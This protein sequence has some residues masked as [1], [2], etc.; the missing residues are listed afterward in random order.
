MSDDVPASGPRAKSENPAPIGELAGRPIGPRPL[1]PLPLPLPKP[2]DGEKYRHLSLKAEKR[3]QV[4]R[5][6]WFRFFTSDW[7]LDPEVSVM[8]AE[9]EASYISLIALCWASS[10]LN[11]GQKWPGSRM[12]VSRALGGAGMKIARRWPRVGMGLEKH[13]VRHS[14]GKW[15][16]KR[17][18][19]ESGFRGK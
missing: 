4:E 12:E 8:N 7:L 1:D 2:M 14:D 9:E 3:A 5:R 17:L 15:W 19:R 18:L 11:F 6:P 10:G 13:F 16:N